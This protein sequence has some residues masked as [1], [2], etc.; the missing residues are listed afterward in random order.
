MIITVVVLIAAG[1]TALFVFPPRHATPTTKPT[2]TSMADGRRA[3]AAPALVAK[4]AISLDDVS[5]TP[6]PGWKVVLRENNFSVVLGSNGREFMHVKVQQTT[7]D[8]VAP[9]F[10]GWTRSPKNIFHLTSVE[11]E[12]ASKPEK[13]NSSHFQQA[14]YARYSGDLSTQQGTITVYGVLGALLNTSTGEAAFIN[15]FTPGSDLRDAAWPDA[16]TMISSML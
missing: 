1:L 6:A 11:V 7:A 13:L 16:E 2:P 12:Q 10:L 3:P 9:I 15:L 5:I 14:Q 4:D 8:D